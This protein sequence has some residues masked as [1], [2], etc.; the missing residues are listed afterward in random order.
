MPSIALATYAELPDLDDDDLPLAR[1]LAALG[2]RV[3][4]AVWNDAGVDWS[5]FDLIVLRSCW[6]YDLDPAGFLRW[7]AQLEA[8]RAPLWN[9]P[10]VATWNVDKRHLLELER[11]GVPIIP[12]LRAPAGD[13]RRLRACLDE[14]EADEAVV[15][16]AVSLSAHGTWRTSRAS[17]AT[18]EARWREQVE[19][20]DLLVQRFVPEIARGGEW[21]FVHLGGAF[22]HACRKLPA[23]G[24]FRVQ[25]ELGGSLE[26][27]EPAPELVSQAERVLAAPPGPHLYSR[28]D[29][30]VVDGAFLL[31]EVELIDPQLYLRVAPDA[32]RRLAELA[33]ARV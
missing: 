13:A 4:P 2:A 19:R 15:K 20:C 3:V 21:S 23:A 33:V 27:V 24:D 25:Q 9:P 17:A 6:D 29:G 1:E 16:P 10:R 14:L 31:M 26:R 18:D 7:L 12:T 22:S 30:V 11:A 28:V 32:A 5:D 8:A